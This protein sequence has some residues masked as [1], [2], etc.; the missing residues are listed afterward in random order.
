[1][2]RSRSLRLIRQGRTTS[3]FTLIEVII[4]IVIFASAMTVVLPNFGAQKENAVFG[5]IGRL[6]ADIRAAYD[7]AVLSGRAHRLVFEMGTGK[8]W[9]ESTKERDFLLS[10]DKF[11]RELT[12]QEIDSKNAEFE[13]DF[14]RYTERKME[15]I[16]DPATGKKI[17]LSTGM[18]NLEEV[19]KKIFG[20]Q[21]GK[22]IGKGYGS[23]L[24]NRPLI[25]RKI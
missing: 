3:G 21:K 23:F 5:L 2:S 8:Y 13:E 17:I 11:E 20:L 25:S 24:K 22:K 6:R 4:V 14:Q 10:G 12:A 19:E 7:L 1:M 18:S 9:L 15:P 16:T